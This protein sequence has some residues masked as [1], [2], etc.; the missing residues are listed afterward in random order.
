MPTKSLKNAFMTH[1][2]PVF[3]ILEEEYGLQ[4]PDE[5]AAMTETEINA[6]FDLC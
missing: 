6:A 1:W 3:G 5:T 4:L 2:K